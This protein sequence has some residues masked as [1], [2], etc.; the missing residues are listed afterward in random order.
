M[1]HFDF[2]KDKKDQK[3]KEERDKEGLLSN[4]EKEDA[5]V[6]AVKTTPKLGFNKV[7][8]AVKDV[9]QSTLPPKKQ[10]KDILDTLKKTVKSNDFEK[11]AEEE[12]DKEIVEHQ[13]RIAHD[14]DDIKEKELDDDSAEGIEKLLKKTSKLKALEMNMHDQEQQ[15]DEWKTEHNAHAEKKVEAEEKEKKDNELMK[16]GLRELATPADDAEKQK[17]KESK[18]DDELPKLTFKT[19]PWEDEQM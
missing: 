7:F 8:N 15:Y 14:Y 4:S 19:T 3:E 6:E 5:I 2:E 10:M 9:K 16:E 13:I 18:A 17:S 1:H 12:K 11:A